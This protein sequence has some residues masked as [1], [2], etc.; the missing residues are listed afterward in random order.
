MRYPVDLVEVE[1]GFNIYIPKA[2]IVRPTYEALLRDGDNVTFPFWAKIWASAKAMTIFLQQEPQWIL[3]KTVIEI[4]AGIGLPSLCIAKQ[5]KHLI[6][7]DYNADAVALLE[8]NI[9]HLHLNQVK[10]MQLDWNEFPDNIKSDTLLLSD[11]NYEPDQFEALLKLIKRFLSAGSTIIIATP[12]RIMAVPFAE[13]LSE[14]IE[15]SHEYTIKEN[16]ISVE[17][18]VFVLHKS[19]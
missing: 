4:G 19:H 18:S 7:S 12:Q 10:A 8:M 3:G 2:E 1:Q 14:S 17:I 16:N 5:T 13:M 9:R 15:Q 11:I 6:I